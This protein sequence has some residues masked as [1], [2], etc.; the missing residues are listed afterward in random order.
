MH[1]LTSLIMLIGFAFVIFVGLVTVIWDLSQLSVHESPVIRE[2]SGE[3]AA[4]EDEKAV[5]SHESSPTKLTD[6][7][8][9][10]SISS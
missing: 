2:A 1:F 5:E 6:T 3:F 4:S 9:L 8:S 7:H 10:N